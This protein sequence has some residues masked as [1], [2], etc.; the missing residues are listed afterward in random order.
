VKIDGLDVTIEEIDLSAKD[1]SPSADNVIDEPFFTACDVYRTAGLSYRQLNNWDLKGVLPNS[2]RKEAGW[3]TFSYR[4]VF[5][6][7]VCS[8]IRTRFGVP[9]YYELEP[10]HQMPS[11]N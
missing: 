6:I 1:L 10:D 11:R 3:R 5:A 2:R 9:P 8:E 7:F 4:E